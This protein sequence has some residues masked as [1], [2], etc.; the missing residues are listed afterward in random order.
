MQQDVITPG[1]AEADPVPEE[2]PDALDADP[3]DAALLEA[4]REAALL[5]DR[6]ET[7]EPLLADDLLLLLLE[8]LLLDE[9]E[10]EDFELLELLLD[11]DE[12]LLLLLL[13]LDLD[14]LLLL[15]LDELL[16]LLDDED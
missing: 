14:E 2:P 8:L 15:D 10:L 6:E 4:L 3:D 9:L 16:L 11:L 12:L 13:L 7:L 1:A 5:A